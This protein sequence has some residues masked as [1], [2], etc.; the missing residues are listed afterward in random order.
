M[1]VL[2]PAT[3]SKTAAELVADGLRDRARTTYLDLIRIFN[4][5]AQEFWRNS[6]VS[7]Q[8]IAT[9]LGVD[10]VEIFQLHAKIGALLAEINPAVIANGLAVVGDFSYNADGTIEI[11]IA[12]TIPPEDLEVDYLNPAN[13]DSQ[14]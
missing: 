10:A 2:N 3:P 13:S 4:G 12:P 14:Q 7:P 11:S 8:D 5:T 6:Q 1:S 9:A